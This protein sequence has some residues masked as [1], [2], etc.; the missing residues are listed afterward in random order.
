M[1]AIHELASSANITQLSSFL[2]SCN[3]FQSSVFNF[4]QI[5]ALINQYMEIDRHATS[6][7]SNSNKQQAMKTLKNTFVL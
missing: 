7:P 6:T 3:V 1:Q 2:G 4:T 5:A